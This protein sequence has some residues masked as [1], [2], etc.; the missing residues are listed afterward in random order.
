MGLQLWN[1]TTRALIFDSG[2]YP[3]QIK[4]ILKTS[5]DDPGIEWGS[6]YAYQIDT[7][8]GENIAVG[9]ST[10]RSVSYA[11]SGADPAI[12]GWL[13]RECAWCVAGT[14]YI[15]NIM[16]TGDFTSYDPA[17]SMNPYT[18]GSNLYVIQT[19]ILPSSYN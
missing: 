17:P 5:Y 15:S 12:Q 18:K 9:F 16:T 14:V 1:P 2:W 11:A 6:D 19:D 10:Y 8:L 13:L 4:K 7:G 3:L